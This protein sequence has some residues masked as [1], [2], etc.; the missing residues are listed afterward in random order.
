MAKSPAVQAIFG[1]TAT[2]KRRRRSGGT[3]G[4]V[5]RRQRSTENADFRS[6]AGRRLGLQVGMVLRRPATGSG[7]GGAGRPRGAQGGASLL[8]RCSDA[9]ESRMAVGGP[10][11]PGDA[12]LQRAAHNKERRV[13]WL[14]LRGKAAGVL[15]GAARR[16]RAGHGRDGRR[17]ADAGLRRSPVG[18]RLLPRW[19][20]W[21]WERVS[22]W[23][24]GKMD[25][26]WW[27]AA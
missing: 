3:C 9:G 11:A 17:R 18:A 14:G 27:A 15:K 2:R 22:S 7:G 12:R 26:A 1:S 4:G 25:R 21:A 6:L 8:R 19:A 23:V 5:H 24:G 20:W 10:A 16:G 13:A